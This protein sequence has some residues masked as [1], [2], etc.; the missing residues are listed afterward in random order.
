SPFGVGM[1]SH[2]FADYEG[3]AEGAAFPAIRRWVFGRVGNFDEHLVR[4]QDDE[5]NFRVA[6]AG[7][8]IYISPRV[9]YA[10]FVRDSV[11]RLFRQYFQYSFWR[12][13]VIRKHK[14]PTTL[15]QIVP[16]LFFL[17]MLLLALAGIW[18]RQPLVALALPAVY[19]TVLVL[20][21][22]S[23]IPK[24]GLAVAS[25]VPVALATIHV[26]YALGLV[27]GFLAAIVYPRAWDHAGSMAT[28]SR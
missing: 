9:R 14:R 7:G 16:P 4:N 24:Q 11:T 22:I 21:G 23:V 26:A 8:K 20:V 15:R 5:W 27:Y 25:L 17:T 1:A 18:L 3:Y 12:I 28:L 2:R 6:Q 13:P 19:C 10:Y